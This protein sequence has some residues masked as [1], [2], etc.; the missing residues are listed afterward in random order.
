MA[1]FNASEQELGSLAL[2]NTD[3][4]MVDSFESRKNELLSLPISVTTDGDYF[5]LQ[6]FIL[7]Q[8]SLGDS[9]FRKF[10][11]LTF[12][13]Q[14]NLA[15]ERI[16]RSKDFELGLI[17]GPVVTK[18]RA[19]HEIQEKTV[20]GKN[21]VDRQKYSIETNIEILEEINYLNV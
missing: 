20:I 10:G 18:D 4:Y 3:L 11:D 1:N 15:I 7:E 17:G 12:E 19:I 5:N 2:D 6:D 9:R 14:S 8:K 13:E 16:K 21:L